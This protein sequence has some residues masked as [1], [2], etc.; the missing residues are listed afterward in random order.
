MLKFRLSESLKSKSEVAQY[1]LYAIICIIALFAAII[2][3]FTAFCRS[4]HLLDITG[5]TVI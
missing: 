2:V 5:A 4:E 3:L 1:I